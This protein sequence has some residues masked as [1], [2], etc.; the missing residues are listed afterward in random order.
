MMSFQKHSRVKS[1]SAKWAVKSPPSKHSAGRRS[2]HGATLQPL[3]G[4]FQ[5]VYPLW[6]LLKVLV[7]QKKTGGARM[8]VPVQYKVRVA[9]LPPTRIWD[10]CWWIH[11]R[12]QSCKSL[13]FNQTQ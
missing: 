8:M 11:G 2:V 12:Y 13:P 1:H 3:Q 4:P 7:E 6:Y 10:R 9:Q 5:S